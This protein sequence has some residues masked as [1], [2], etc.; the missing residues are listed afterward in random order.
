M[1]RIRETYHL[2]QQQMW[3][4]TAYTSE[5]NARAWFD[6]WS[7]LILSGFN[8]AKTEL[9]DIA[10]WCAENSHRWH[11]PGEGH[12][13][14]AVAD[15]NISFAIAY[16]TYEGRKPFIFSQIDYD[17]RGGYM[18]HSVS[19]TKG[20]LVIGAKFPWKGETVK[21]TTF[22]DEKHSLIACAYHPDPKGYTPSKIKKRFTISVDDL[23]KQKKEKNE[24][25]GNATAS[26]TA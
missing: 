19:K 1:S 22:K 24:S 4:K 11:P 21:V 20:R 18:C 17:R 7:L 5:K 16:E 13:T 12:Y 23:R 15:S 10:K 3:E 6:F 25:A 26:K 2:F 8:F 9:R 14:L